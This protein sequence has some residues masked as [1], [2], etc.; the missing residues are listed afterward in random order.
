MSNVIRLG[1]RPPPDFDRECE[2]AIFIANDAPTNPMGIAVP[3]QTILQGPASQ[4]DEPPLEVPLQVPLPVFGIAVASYFLGVFM[5]CLSI[6]I[7]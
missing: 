7:F 3:W 2:T 4:P 6:W 1:V 5:T